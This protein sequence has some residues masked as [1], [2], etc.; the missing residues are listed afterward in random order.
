MASLACNQSKSVK[1]GTKSALIAL[2]AVWQARTHS[3]QCNQRHKSSPIVAHKASFSLSLSC[4]NTNSNSNLVLIQPT[5]CSCFF[6]FLLDLWHHTHTQTE[7]RREQSASLCVCSQLLQ[8]DPLCSM[9]WLRDE[10]V[11]RAEKKRQQCEQKVPR[12]NNNNN[13]SQLILVSC[14]LVAQT[15]SFARAQS[16]SARW[17]LARQAYSHTQKQSTN[18]R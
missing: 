14:P 6:C 18:K 16:Q 10:K 1:Y 13:K 8:L 2:C 11:G 15:W 4:T 17:S 12:M 9:W 3:T 7:I 5:C